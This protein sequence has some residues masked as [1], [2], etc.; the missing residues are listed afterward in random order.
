MDKNPNIV[1]YFSDQQRFDTLGCN[2]QKLNVTPVLDKLAEKG[3]NFKR[4]YTCQPVCGP[5]R[6]MLQT[7][8][9]PT[10]VGCFRNA[11]SL[12]QDQYTM[13]ERL[14]DTGYKV[15]YVGKWHLA[16]DKKMPDGNNAEYE[17]SAVPLERRGGY[18]DYWMASD[19]LEFT[20]HGYNGY[21][22][23]QYGEKH[24]FEGYR[25]DCITDY[26]LEYLDQRSSNE[27]EPFFLM[28]SHIEP[29]HQNDHEQFEGPNGSKER[30]AGFDQPKDLDQGCGDWESQMPDYL[31]CCRS[32]DD[33]LGRIIEKLKA[34]GLYENTVI[35]YTSDHGC[36]FKTRQKDAVGEGFDDYKRSC[37]ENTI[38]IPMVISGPGFEEGISNQQIVELIDIPKTIVNI[39]GGD[40]SGMQGA[41]LR[42]CQDGSVDWRKEAYIQI[43]ES[44]VGRAIRTE[45]WTYCIYDPTKNPTKDDGSN[46]YIER[47]LFDNENDPTQLNNLVNDPDYQSVRIELAERLK[48][49]AEEAGEPRFEIVASIE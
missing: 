47:Y 17:T 33:N 16:T 1:F 14:R 31:G 19:V 45:K 29:H 32:L 11:I 12:P 44:Y 2:G 40:D 27:E 34:Q 8:L 28:I 4:A 5:A 21:V 30:F 49:R 20:S 24:E 43:S 46:R 15:A 6:A 36:H 39:A 18:N 42:N 41:D 3:V 48:V 26:A 22:F 13:A 35:I 10:Q 7:G 37:Y 23:D 38:H 9:Y 25:A